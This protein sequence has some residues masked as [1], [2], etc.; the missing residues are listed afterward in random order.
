MLDLLENN[1]AAFIEKTRLVVLEQRKSALTRERAQIVDL[2]ESAGS[3]SNLAKMLNIKRNLISDWYSKSKISARGAN[4][5]HN[6]PTLGKIYTR[7]EL[8]PDVTNWNISDGSAIKN[9]RALIS[10]AGSNKRLSEL[11]G[12]HRDRVQYWLKTGK[13]TKSGAIK[14]HNHPEL[15]KIYTREFLRPDIK[16][17]D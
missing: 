14:I 7:S 13:I 11:L 2:I 15:G 10:Q 4:A 16:N 17:W 5:I 1:D 12:I 3:R 6:H 9:I 8:R